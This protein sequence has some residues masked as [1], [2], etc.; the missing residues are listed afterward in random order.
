MYF[1]CQ[2]YIQISVSQLGREYQFAWVLVPW[3]SAWL[4]IY[5]TVKLLVPQRQYIPMPICIQYMKNDCPACIL[6]LLHD[7]TVKDYKISL[8]AWHF[9]CTDRKNAILGYLCSWHA[10]K[11]NC[12]IFLISN[13]E[14][15]N[16][17]YGLFHGFFSLEYIQGVNV[18]WYVYMFMFSSFH[19]I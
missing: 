6:T 13:M 8:M 18:L 16:V 10:W 2:C 19:W 1:R 12:N 15:R 3:Y 9:H 7:L 14:K 4:L 11:L 17:F 5:A